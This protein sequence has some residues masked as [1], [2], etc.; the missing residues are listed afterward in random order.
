[1]RRVSASGT[2]R[3]SVGDFP[4]AQATASKSRTVS[5]RR[6]ATGPS[7]LHAQRGST[8]AFSTPD[9]LSCSRMSKA[10]AGEGSVLMPRQLQLFGEYAIEAPIEEGPTW[11]A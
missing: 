7:D 4:L 3:A 6:S 10:P 1:M 11:A 5:T 2:D 8:L 9:R